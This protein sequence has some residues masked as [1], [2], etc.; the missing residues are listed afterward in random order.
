MTYQG[1][2]LCGAARYEVGK[3]G[4]VGHCHCS[5]CRKWHAAAFGTYVDIEPETFRWVQGEETVGRYQ[6]TSH[7]A[8]HFCRQCGSPLV[9]EINGKLAA[10]TLATV[11]NAPALEADFHMFVSSKSSWYQIRDALPQYDKY[12]PSMDPPPES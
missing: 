2:C 7:S 6:S 4:H 12:P 1:S 5:Y 3:L 10:V 8:R 9:A 11:E